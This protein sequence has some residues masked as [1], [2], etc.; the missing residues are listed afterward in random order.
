MA[1]AKPREPRR[2]CRRGTVPGPVVRRQQVHVDIIDREG[3]LPIGISVKLDGILLAC[4]LKAEADRPVARSRGPVVGEFP[5]G[6]D[7]LAQG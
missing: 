5:A 7:A 4:R 1:R 6:Q 3:A 2:R